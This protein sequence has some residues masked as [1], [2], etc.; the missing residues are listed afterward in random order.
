MLTFRKAKNPF[1]ENLYN[2]FTDVHSILQLFQSVYTAP[3]G[4]VDG[5]V[6]EELLLWLNVNYIAPRSEE[7][8]ALIKHP[9]PWL[10]ENFWPYL[11]KYAVSIQV[12]SWPSN[13]DLGLADV[14]FEAS[15]N[16]HNTSSLASPH[17]LHL[18]SD[19]LQKP[20]Q[21]S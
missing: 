15:P 2:H 21:T 7:G 12:P 10:D 5:L 18:P 6:G 19:A 17:I 4:N 9:K 13:S 14:F 8:Q 1:N 16:L 20:S 3:T 11:T